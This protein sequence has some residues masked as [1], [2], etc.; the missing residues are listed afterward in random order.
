MPETHWHV[1]ASIAQFKRHR[2]SAHVDPRQPLRGLH[3]VQVDGQ[4]MRSLEIL[5]VDLSPHSTSITAPADTYVRVADLVATF[6]GAPQAEMRTEVY[7]RGDALHDLHGAGQPAVG[8]VELMISVQT[9][10]LDSRP[11]LGTRS[12]LPAAEMLQL[13]DAVRGQFEVLPSVQPGQSQSLA[14]DCPRCILVRLADADLSYAE[15]VH[16]ADPGQSQVFRPSED[17]AA[18]GV[19]ELRHQLFAAGLEKGVI[20]RARVLGVLLERREDE[21]AAADYFQA[22]AATAPPLTR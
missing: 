1:D 9:N 17:Q 21:A 6:N 5:G 20:L 11:Q 13:V 16:P 22:F 2:L 12:Q 18:P 10:L 7:W 15:M 8:A 3:E 19:C 14:A 4:V